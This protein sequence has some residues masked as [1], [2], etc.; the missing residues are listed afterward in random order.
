MTRAAPA[1]L[2]FLSRWIDGQWVVTCLNYN[3]AAQDDTLPGARARVQ[4]QV[5]S[6]MDLVRE[7][8]SMGFLLS[9]KAPFTDWLIYALGRFARN[10]LGA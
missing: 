6:Y 8:P 3:L 7:N 9:R 4:A 10:L 5:D 2:H 1:R